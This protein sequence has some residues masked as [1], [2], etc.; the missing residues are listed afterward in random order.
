M[1]KI[2]PRDIQI[3]WRIYRWKNVATREQ[4]E[5]LFF[6]SSQTAKVRIEKLI[7]YRLIKECNI[8]PT[9]I[10]RLTNKG[11]ALLKKEFKGDA[12]KLKFA[13]VAP[14]R[15]FIKH[16]IQTND[17]WTALIARNDNGISC[18]LFLP[19]YWGIGEGFERV[20]RCQNSGSV[21]DADG[22]FILSKNGESQLFFLE[23]DRGTQS[24]SGSFLNMIA[25]YQ[26]FLIERNF[27]M[28][29]RRLGLPE[30]ELFRL[31]IVTS[32]RAR[33]EHIRKATLKLSNRISEALRWFW[34]T[35]VE[36]TPENVY[37]PIWNSMDWWDHKEYSLSGN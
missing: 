16:H 12:K 22:I 30:F 26:E 35:G 33:V 13:K 28:I 23:I 36:V 17:F 34:V 37:E 21:H 20:T 32:S 31:L 8:L 11:E 2:R 19:Y 14:D 10:Y 18:P 25:F 5:R 7:G 4:I 6:P 29:S 24:I 1:D 9:A 15:R 3:L 27:K